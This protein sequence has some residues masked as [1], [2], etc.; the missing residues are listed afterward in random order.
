[1]KRIAL[2]GIVVVVA[3]GAVA[4]AHAALSPKALRASIVAA[5][6]AQKS[7]HW[8]EHDLVGGAQI[9]SSA[10]VGAN[11]GTQRVTVDV[12]RQKGTIHIV[13][14][15]HTA[16]VSGDAFGL[17][18]NLGLTKAQAKQFANTWISIPRGDKAY[19]AVSGGLTLAS[20]IHGV[21]PRGTLKAVKTKEH[22]MRVFVLEGAKGTGKKRVV[23]T[24]VARA[25]GKPLPIESIAV[26]PAHEVL[27]RAD[28]SKW[29]EPVHVAAPASPTPIATVRG[30]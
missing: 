18:A 27:S 12:G 30:G 2:T 26:D 19:R 4:G 24:I 29:N 21:T 20:I 16:Y 28:F 14:I 1:V 9:S 6:L 13:F 17:V 22:G 15:S 23:G 25:S 5:A 11:F 8:A 7:V 3:A 10:D